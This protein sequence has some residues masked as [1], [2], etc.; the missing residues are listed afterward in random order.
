[1]SLISLDSNPNDVVK[2]IWEMLHHGKKTYNTA[3][4]HAQVATVNQQF[5]PEV[6][7]MILRQVDEGAPSVCFNLDIRSSKAEQIRLNS[8]VHCLFYD[9]AA[10][11]QVRLSCIGKICYNDEVSDTAWQKARIQSQLSYL[12]EH[13]PGTKLL[14]PPLLDVNRTD[15]TLEELALAKNNF[16][17]L[18]CKISHIDILSLNH[19]SNLRIGYDCESQQAYWLHP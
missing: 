9:E 2:N 1:M 13:A 12:T 5:C 7:T 8:N 10:R 17:V 6:R 4:H 14:K 11:V 16:A 3:F 15:A 18:Q 19:I